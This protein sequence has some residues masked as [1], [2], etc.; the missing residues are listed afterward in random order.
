MKNSLAGIFFVLFI[1]SFAFAS[2]YLVTD[3]Q[4]NDYVLG[5]YHEI[6][7]SAACYNSDSISSCN[8]G[9]NYLRIAE[10][11]GA[12][13]F[14]YESGNA[15]YCTYRA[16]S[17]GCGILVS[18]PWIEATA[19][20]TSIPPQNT[21]PRLTA[22]IPDAS[23]YTTSSGINNSP[24]LRSYF[25]DN[26]TSDNNLRFSIV[27]QTNTSA[28]NCNISGSYYISCLA[29]ANEG[30]SDITVRAYDE[31]DAYVDDTFR[32]NVTRQAPANSNP[33]ISDV[34]DFAVDEGSPALGHRYDLR[35]YAY[36]NETSTNSLRFSVVSQGSSSVINCYIEDSYYL[37]CNAPYSAGY[38]D[39]VVRVYDSQNAYADDSFRI[40]VRQSPSNSSPYWPSNI[41]DRQT[42]YNDPAMGQFADLRSYAQDNESPDNG[43]RFSIASQGNSSVISCYV[44]STYYLSCNSPLSEG[45]SDIRVR[46]YDAQNSYSDDTFRVTVNRSSQ[47]TNPSISGLPNLYTN[48]DG[49][50][51]H[52]WI[53]LR[54]Y[55][56]DNESPDNDLRFSVVSQSNSPAI[57]C[58]IENTYY[59]SC[60][61]PGREGSS[62]ILV[63]VYDGQNNYDEDILRVVVEGNGNQGNAPII[64]GLPSQ[65]IEENSGNSYRLI[66]LWNYAYDNEDS[67]SQ[68]YFSV[69]RQTNS[70]L[71][72]CR[73]SGNRWLECDAPADNRTGTNYVTIRAEDSDGLADEAVARIEVV[74]DGR[75]GSCSSGIR[76]ITND[77]ELSENSSEG[78]SFRIEN[79]SSRDFYIDEINVYDSIS[80]FEADEDSYPSRIDSDD[81]GI[82]DL[83]VHAYSVSYTR[84][85]DAYIRVRGHF[86]N[87]SG[88]EKTFSFR[89]RVLDEGSGS[90]GADCPDMG[91]YTND[92]DMYE[93]SSASKTFTIR[94][95]SDRDFTIDNVYANDSSSYFTVSE[96]ST[97][98][99]V[100]A[101]SSAT[102]RVNANSSG[103][104]QDITGKAKVS[105]N[106]RFSNGSY[107]STSDIYEEFSVKVRNTGSQP[108]DNGEE[109][110][111]EIDLGSSAIN[112]VGSGSKETS[113]DIKNNSNREQCIDFSAETS[114]GYVSASLGK[115]RICIASGSTKGNSVKITAEKTGS[116]TVKLRASYNGNEKL[117]IIS[118]NVESQQGNGT[119]E[120]RVEITNY[121]SSVKLDYNSSR[122]ISISIGNSTDKD[123]KNVTV[124][125]ESLPNGIYA[126]PVLREMVISGAVATIKTQ[127]QNQGAVA[128]KYSALLRV[129]YDGGNIVKNVEIEVG[130]KPQS[131]GAT[132]LAFLA[133]SLTLALI[134]IIALLL[135]AIAIIQYTRSK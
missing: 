116:Y 31:E 20:C 40:T 11:I 112:M 1:S 44:D 12:E 67:D 92:F 7:A 120:G 69:S 24:D 75:N 76:A 17:V 33:R 122:D 93:N 111:V 66:D 45:Y 91:F 19:N 9:S 105:L 101:N 87:D 70:S 65:E 98:S 114:S 29:P 59:L 25:Q 78:D 123:I 8:C 27:S 104:S 108:P 100:Y 86:S 2:N 54:G 42:N 85:N 55:A 134:V 71:V 73:I 118:L 60:G 110:D 22:S 68:L 47:N 35:N 50:A 95:D 15:C 48:T 83:D 21:Q 131:Q 43:L 115:S 97:L 74:E 41:P 49:S 37:S 82:L 94:N 16:P 106:G 64:S 10:L 88:C 103:V 14:E 62:E 61:T 77:I 102:F 99:K 113:F 13:L 132:G 56:Q 96:E 81:Y 51:R 80:Y 84:S 3:Y 32:V 133:N 38:S 90:A 39:V 130:E 28:I 5:A 26:E 119:G 72:Y 18:C 57:D 135:I 107:C 121:S 63:R 36:D 52:E 6:T 125:F 58:Y 46:V 53:D 117:Q 89:V 30:Y 4:D 126:K 129:S 127:M 124:E 109:E 34:P 128:G 23:I 79:N